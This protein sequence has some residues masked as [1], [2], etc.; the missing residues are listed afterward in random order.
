M[1]LIGTLKVNMAWIGNGRGYTYGLNT[2]TQIFSIVGM[3]I[4][5]TVYCTDHNRVFTYNG[6]QWVCDDFVIMVNRSASTINQ[7]DVVVAGTGGTATEISCTTTATSGNPGVVGVAVATATT[8][9]NVLIAV[10]GNWKCNVAAS[11]STGADLTTSTTVGKAQ[12][13]AGSFSEGV[14][15]YATT[16]VSGS[17]TVN[18]IIT[19]RKELN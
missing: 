11:T 7:W 4:G 14:F 18:C 17:G 8:G 12:N 3:Q 15:G 16:S 13:N 6:A 5:E 10:K 9:S 19:T 2:L 1:E